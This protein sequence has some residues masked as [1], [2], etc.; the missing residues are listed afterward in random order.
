MR[1]KKVFAVLTAVVMA[2]VIS[3]C[4]NSGKSEEKAAIGNPGTK[5]S[6][7]KEVAEQDALI[8]G[9]GSEFSNMVPMSNNV[10]LANRDGITIFA[11]YDPLLWFDTTTSELK[12]WV[13]EEWSVSDDGL[14]Y[15][16]KLRD[17]VY[18]HNGS[19]MTAED[20]AW[21]LNLIPENPVPCTDNMPY[22]KNA[23]VI[24]DT[25]VKFYM[26]KPFAAMPN[27]LASYHLVVL[28]K[29]YYD[30]VG[31]EGYQAHP[32]GT[33]PYKF[34]TRVLGGSLEL[35]SFED[36]W[37][38]AADIKK[39]MLRILPDSNSQILS[40]ETGEINVLMNA[41]IQNLK[42]IENEKGI[43]WDYCDSFKACY[44]N[45]GY[46]SE[47]QTDENLRK[48][49]ASAINY[50]AINDTLNFGYTKPANCLIAPGVTARPD[51]GT[52]T[53]SLK[54]DPEAAKQYL[55]ASDYKQGKA[56]RIICTAGS[57][58]ENICKI[59]QG[60]LQA[61]GV[62]AELAALDGATFMTSQNEGDFDVA[63]YSTLPSLYDANLLYQFF[64]RATNIYKLSQY[65]DK[66]KLADI[67]LA[68]H[69]EADPEKRKALFAEMQD[70]I[71][72]H[73]YQTYLYY[74]VNTMSWR[75]GVEGIHAIPG[76]NYR[77]DE[78]SWEK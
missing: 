73:C 62:T 33:G 2:A 30:E 63:I 42:R 72:E 6:V 3:G 26:E 68:T 29:D 4:G 77:I 64:N 28:S 12:S 32:I 22:F 49:L 15:T 51:D 59:I 24:D 52:F 35:E 21:T 58:E 39:V 54:Y 20:V 46:K 47:L 1:R 31:W 41:S 45:W 48:A 74:D 34:V 19:K 9:I 60:D 37:G 66:E 18:F 50:E 53:D 36:Y 56:L 8:I 23:E 11:L 65:P 55:A 76:T 44:V 38:G 10:A 13:C 78:W 70:L 67:A 25:T 71:N 16:L 75:D 69:G 61:I 43:N 40:L 27:A 57:V 17:D 7:T 14:E 5:E